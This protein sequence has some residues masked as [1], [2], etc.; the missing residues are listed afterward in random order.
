MSNLEDLNAAVAIAATQRSK[1]NV[2]PLR[3]TDAE[4]IDWMG[5]TD[6]VI[7]WFLRTTSQDEASFPVIAERAKRFGYNGAPLALT[8]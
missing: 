7:N 1:P 4:F 8:I 2:N 3:M 6:A 5:D